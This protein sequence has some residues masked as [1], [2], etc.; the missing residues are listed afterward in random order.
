MRYLLFFLSTLCTLTSFAQT[1]SSC[2]KIKA[3][4]YTQEFCDYDTKN[5][6]KNIRFGTA[7][8]AISSRFSLT[9]SQT[10][11][12]KYESKDD[13]AKFWGNVKFDQ[14]LFEFNSE[15]KLEGVQLQMIGHGDTDTEKSKQNMAAWSRIEDY[16][17]NLFGKPEKFHESL[18]W[19]GEN[20]NI[21]LGG[22]N[23]ASNKDGSGAL[24]IFTKNI[25]PV[26]DL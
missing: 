9:K 22:Y 13:E 18:L 8:D 6:Y 3:R 5:G 2:S 19:R 23:S 10:N 21:V 26:D 15:K 25:N 12:Y 17:T 16:L 11:P 7:F 24:A 20:V 1:N 4:G 14:C